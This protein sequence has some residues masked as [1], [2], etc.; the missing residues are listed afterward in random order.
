M[1]AGTI[2]VF[3]S[4]GIGCDS[5]A[6]EHQDRYSK[7]LPIHLE[8]SDSIL[9]LALDGAFAD[10]TLDGALKTCQNLLHHL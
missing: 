8:S 3:S 7:E 4:I 5:F 2:I 6:R 1:E 9:T 10:T